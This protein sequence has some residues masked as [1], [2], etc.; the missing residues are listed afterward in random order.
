MLTNRRV[1]Q[2]T[3]DVHATVVVHVEMIGMKGDIVGHEKRIAQ[4][5]TIDRGEIDLIGNDVRQRLIERSPW[6]KDNE[7]GTVDDPQVMVTNN[8]ACG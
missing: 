4:S 1:D 5:G 8:H 3:G 2:G 6:G 7:M